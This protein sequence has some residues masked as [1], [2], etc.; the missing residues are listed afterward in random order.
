MS[1]IT[2]R[3]RAYDVVYRLTHKE[4]I[5]NKNARWHKL[6]K[7]EI[8]KKTRAYY[9]E[10]KDEIKANV[11]RTGVELRRRQ[12]TAVLYHYSNGTMACVQ[13]GFSDVRALCLDHVNGGGTEHRRKL[14]NGINVWLWL[15]RHGF[16]PGYQILC[17]NCN[18]IKAREEDEYG[19][20]GKI[21]SDWRSQ[22]NLPLVAKPV[23]VDRRYWE[24]TEK[25]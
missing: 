15:A 8:S 4:E 25:V 22:L 24:Y 11:K 1:K 2:D 3:E 10:H 13:C 14:R 23:D 21:K 20:G 19:S 16:P 7:E 12:R 18:M 17:A 9:H 5:R 6:H